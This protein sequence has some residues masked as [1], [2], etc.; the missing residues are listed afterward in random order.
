MSGFRVVVAGRPN[1]GKSAL[2]NRLLRRRRSLVHDMPG[3]TRDVLE[4]EASLPDG[5]TYRLLDTGGF[6]PEG[7]D[8]IPAAVRDKALQS[9]RSADLVLLVTD[10]SAGVLPGDRVA[11]KVARE[12]GVETVVVANK[13][14]RREGSEGEVEAWE[15]G[16]DEVFG[17]SAEHGLGIDEL[18]DAIAARVPATAEESRERENGKRET[19]EPEK[20]GSAE[21]REIRLAVVGRPNVGKSSLVNALLGEDRAIVSDVAGTTR[22]ASDVVFERAGKTFRLVDTAGIRRKAKT[23]RG[24]EVLSV[25][26]ARKRIEECDVALIVL[27]AA[28]GPTAQ[29]AAVAA[30]AHESGK[31][32]VLVANKWDLAGRESKEASKEFEADVRERLPFAG[33]AEVLRVS[34]RTGRGVGRILPAA[35][36]AAG[37]RRRRV[38]TGELNRVLG[39][40]LRDSPPQ[41]ARGPRL[42]VYYVAQTGVG[43]PT[44]TIVGN[45]EEALHFSETRRIENLVREASDFTGSPIRISV[46]GRS[47][48]GKSSS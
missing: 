25:V 9:I 18:Q 29:D 1:V 22:D 33:Y 21:P 38:S 35:A 30:F 39:R 46:R 28:N 37:N 10:A 44:F 2:F 13:V 12:A 3:M 15:L 40:A 14:D 48:K 6:D 5:R 17:V 8:E 24:P 26:Q 11:A 32:L 42:K 19:G 27:D 41:T 23:E 47:R 4:V 45:R 34:A 43:P 20:A 31:G 7:K 36:R 16:F